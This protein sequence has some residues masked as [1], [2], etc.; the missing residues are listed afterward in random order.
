MRQIGLDQTSFEES[1][2]TCSTMTSSFETPQDRAA[3]A[4]DSWARGGSR[5]DNSAPAMQFVTTL[6]ALGDILLPDR[7]PDDDSPPQ[8]LPHA[9]RSPFQA[10]PLG[11]TQQ[12]LRPS[13][14]SLGDEMP[15]WAP[16]MPG[17]P[18][19]Q[20]GYGAVQAATYSSTPSREECRAVN[21]SPRRRSAGSVS[22]DAS[23]TPIPPKKKTSDA[24]LRLLAAR[25]KKKPDNDDVTLSFESSMETSTESSSPKKVSSKKSSEPP[26][27]VSSKSKS[28]TQGSSSSSSGGAAIRMRRSRSLEDHLVPAETRILAALRKSSSCT[29]AASTDDLEQTSAGFRPEA[30]QTLRSNS[31]GFFGR[32]LSLLRKQSTVKRS[33]LPPPKD[34]LDNA[35]IIFDWDD[36]LLPT[37]YIKQVVDPK[38]P[39]LESIRLGEHQEGPLTTKSPHFEKFRKNALVVEQVL[40]EARKVARVDIVTLATKNWVDISAERYFPGLDVQ[41]LLRELDI[42]VYHCDRQ[43]DLFQHIAQSGRDPCLAAKKAAMSKCLLRL[44]HGSNLHWNVLSIGDSVC[45]RDALKECLQGAKDAICKTIKIREN[46]PIA[47]L[48][49]DLQLLIPNLMSLA[50]HQ[51]DF[52]RTMENLDG[53]KPWNKILGI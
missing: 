6:D 26:V 35:V 13:V 29:F 37:T 8:P 33:P 31:G 18:E 7:L 17:N 15:E 49:K 50:G 22:D 20:R 48:T 21:K 23:A 53:K 16:P 1:H 52:D 51:Q 36:T 41:E 2:E 42:E 28:K 40:R 25:K 9:V 27:R 19:S 32:G 39:T 43:S 47:D 14:I 38:L 24:T 11:A 4:I 30:E 46:L 45:E 44:Y 12:T 34:S 3:T 10:F 5:R